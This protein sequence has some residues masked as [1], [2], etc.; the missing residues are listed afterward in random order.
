M[1]LKKWCYQELRFL[2]NHKS[3]LLEEPLL[4]FS[5]N[6]DEQNFLKEKVVIIEK[7]EEIQK[8]CDHSSFTT[9]EIFSFRPCKGFKKQ[10]KEC[11]LCGKRF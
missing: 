8:K 2:I 7:I 1:N 11:S 5:L 10:Q 9:Y 4:V 3:K 6:L